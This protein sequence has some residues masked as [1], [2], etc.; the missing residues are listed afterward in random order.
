MVEGPI[1]ILTMTLAS[2]TQ[3]GSYAV[4]SLLG[5]GGMGEVYKARDT[6][7]NR[8]VALKTLSPSLREDPAALARFGREAHI[9][10]GLSHPN[11]VALFDVDLDG[12]PPLVVTEFLAGEPL[13]ALLQKGPVPVERVRNLALQITEALIAAHGR[14]IVH[15]DLK[16]SNVFVTRG[17]GLKLLD[18]G[19]AKDLKL[20]L[21]GSATDARPVP[22]L[23][24]KGTLL[25][26][27]GYMAP[28]Q[29]RGEG[30]DARSDL[31]AL[32][33]L[34]L[35]ML[36]GK[37][38]F[39]GDSAVE[40]LHAI[41]RVDPLVGQNIPAPFRPVLE[42][43]LAKDPEDR[44]QTARD[45]AFMLRTPGF[46]TEPS[47]HP[48]RRNRFALP[49]ACSLLL[50]AVAALGWRSIQVPSP[51]PLP[52]WTT[53][54]PFPSAVP[55]AR[56]S[57]DGKSVVFTKGGSGGRMELYRYQDGE[58][59]PVPIGQSGKIVAVGPGGELFFSGPGRLAF[60]ADSSLSGP[61]YQ[62]T[63]P[64]SAPRVTL[65]DVQ[66][67]DVS[68]NGTELAIVRSPEVRGMASGLMGTTTLEAPPGKVLAHSFWMSHPR[69]SPD[70]RQ[71]AYIERREA[72]WFTGRICV[73]DRQGNQVFR[74]SEVRQ[75]RGLAWAP[76]GRDLVFGRALGDG[77][78]LRISAMD[79]KGRIRDLLSASS[80]LVMMDV[81]RDGRLLIFGEDW[82][83][84]WELENGG[85]SAP[86]DLPFPPSSG[87]TQSPDGRLVGFLALETGGID[88]AYYRD[89]STG[90]LT[91]LTPRTLPLAFTFDD[92]WL[93]LAKWE[94]A[95]GSPTCSVL[96]LGG[97]QER[98][99][100]TQGLG[101]CASGYLPD[102]DHPLVMADTSSGDLDGP[103]LLHPKAP[104]ER[105]AKDLKS[106]WSLIFT[107]PTDYFAY[108]QEHGLVH[109]TLQGDRWTPVSGPLTQYIPMGWDARTQELL[110][111]PSREVVPLEAQYKP[112]EKLT[113]SRLSVPTLRLHPDQVLDLR[114]KGL[115][116]YGVSVSP[117]GIICSPSTLGGTLHVVDGVLPPHP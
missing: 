20:D 27:V 39:T 109:G 19:L 117:R 17:E 5:S 12:T 74:S 13:S 112:V 44:F 55:A 40:V 21:E 4:I 90:A 80:N 30:A 54:T 100:N 56:F 60:N 95:G 63:G 51:K 64:L 2:G 87:A 75:I 70:G 83:F 43:L 41:L 65:D 72:S 3:L 103:F 93:L 104:P 37:Q 29:V 78:P 25:G 68:P 94:Q 47:T 42:R 66:E 79:L 52:R 69:W 26:T 38:A 49:V 86:F 89:Q 92:R 32:G 77:S 10:A 16:P 91:R 110:V 88:C 57:P 81:S 114:G 58:A 7:L 9:L 107:G 82:S 31:F 101:K 6:R 98:V 34:I 24:M 35:E 61:L 18:F 111:V 67:A 1:P 22:S 23:T 99:F 96:P 28:E 85:Q 76:N 46:T 48:P 71:I 84:R 15:R 108:D 33:V 45:L 113:L 50:A 115:S 105:I 8:L 97:G 62:W 106:I 59:F 11:I 73:I 102:P 53:L 116:F 14:G 36:T